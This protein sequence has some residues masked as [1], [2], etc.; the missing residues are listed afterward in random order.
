[1]DGATASA[2]AVVHDSIGGYLTI[3][4]SLGTISAPELTSFG[5]RL[6]HAWHLQNPK[7]LFGDLPQPRPRIVLRR[8]VRERVNALYAPFLAADA[9]RPIVHNDTLYWS[10][11]L[12]AASEWYPLSEPVAVSGLELHY[13]RPAA[14]A[15]VNA[16]TGRVWAIRDDIIDPITESW[17]RRF[18]SLFV[19]RSSITPEFLRKIAPP[20]EV[21]FV[22]ARAF[23]RYGRR[24]D[25][26]PPSRLPQSTG[27]EETFGEYAS[28]PSFDLRRSR[29]FWSIPILDAANVV[30]GVYI[31]MGGGTHDPL[32]VTLP[33]STTR[34]PVLLERMQSS[35]DAT[36]TLL[37]RDARAIRGPVRS[38]PHAGGIAFVQSTYSSRGD[39][40][41]ALA[42]AVVV[43]G[44]S[45]RAGPSVMSA[46]GVT[47]ASTT[48]PPATPE[49]FRARVDLYY[50]QMREAL[51]RSD[52]SAFGEAFDALGRML[53]SRGQTP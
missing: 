22:Q 31:A 30:R 9:I 14:V 8:D 39:G 43:V 37:T 38:I 52:W 25:V 19:S 13:L 4:D 2:P 26:A 27:G 23:A 3:A 33:A 51:Q 15:I 35:G 45:T 34:W 41:L 1:M 21:S 40:T 10:L 49:E 7:L 12:Y 16:T 5:T 6:A 47:P 42:R 20:L 48:V 11:H 29:S 50:R 17:A 46:L 18:P 32:Y 24:G 36:G 28:V 44:D 53:R